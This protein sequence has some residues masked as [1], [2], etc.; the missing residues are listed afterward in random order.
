LPTNRRRTEV[1]AAKS[2]EEL[3]ETLKNS[4]FSEPFEIEEIFN[5][6]TESQLDY[7]AALGIDVP[8]N[9]SKE[10]VSAL[11]SRAVDGDGA[12]PNPELIE[13]ATD[14]G[15]VFSQYIGKRALYNLIFNRLP[16]EDK[17][18]FFCFCAY[19]WLSDDRQG[20]LDRHKYK[21]LF[22]EFAKQQFSNEKFVKSLENYAGE[23]IR[24]FGTLKFTD[25]GECSGGS[26][27][28]IAYKTCANFLKNKLSLNPVTVKTVRA[29]GNGNSELK[30]MSLRQIVET[31]GK[32][33]AVKQ[34]KEEAGVSLGVAKSYV[35]NYMKQNNITPAKS[36]CTGVIL[37]FIII[38]S[39]SIYCATG[40]F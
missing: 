19:R 9:A 39:L 30:K 33:Y 37:I 14:R 21:P 31:K 17:I 2:K 6:P 35:E 15:L 25:G 27:N 1:I 38:S 29:S 10:D 24:F 22:Y 13:F 18:A 36:G 40:V 26:V 12:E 23:E 32:I 8:K 5:E 7:A 11:I 20:N 34:Y 3:I 16:L 4:E 28:T